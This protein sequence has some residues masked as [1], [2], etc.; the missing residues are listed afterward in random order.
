MLLKKIQF[1]LET[2]FYRFLDFIG[3][4]KIFIQ[5][6]S[7]I[8]GV[9]ITLDTSKILAG[10]HPVE[11]FFHWLLFK[12]PL[13]I[14]FATLVIL[15][16]YA[17]I[18]KCAIG[19][20]SKLKK[21]LRVKEE[22]LE[23]L[24]NYIKE[25]FEG[26][27][28]SFANAEL[29]FGAQGQNKERISL[30]L[31]KKDQ[32]NNIDYLYPIARYS[33]NPCFRNVRRSKYSVTKGCIGE[34][35]KNDYCYNGNITKEECTGL[36]LYT[37]EEYSAMRMKSKTIAAMAVKDKENRVIG[38]LV[39]ES[40]EEKWQMTTIKRKLEKQSKYYAEICVKLSDYIDSKVDS[41]ENIKGEMPW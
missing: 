33:S 1:Y 29:S 32:S 19:S 18:E 9:I 13:I 38:I 41:K 39:A 16:L 21:E 27:L 37:E 14:F 2:L 6:I 28:M 12:H 24:N 5:S 35:Y 26:L 25:L 17:I 11:I 20:Y 4:S 40:M 3:W 30:Y 36:Y 15:F 10:S 8:Y 7:G 31:V 22:K 34:A 23:I